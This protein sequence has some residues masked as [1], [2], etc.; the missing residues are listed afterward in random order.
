[1]T[2]IEWCDETINPIIGCAKISAGCANC[3]AE[4]MANCHA[5]NPKLAERYGPVITEGHW[6]GKTAFV[7][8]ELEKPFKWKKPK[9]IF[10]GSMGDLFHDRVDTARLDEILATIGSLPRHRFMFLTKR[11]D[12]MMIYFNNLTS[13]ERGVRFLPT[14]RQWPIP[15]LWLG[16]TI[17]NQK[18]ADERIPILLQIPAAKRF[19]S[20]EPMLGPIQL[21]HSTDGMPFIGYSEGGID[22]VICGAETGP[23]ARPMQAAWAESLRD[24][25]QAS[26]VPF[27]FKKFANGDT[28]LNGREWS[29]FPMPCKQKKRAPS[30]PMPSKQTTNFAPLPA[31][32]RKSIQ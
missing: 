8:S 17:E 11:A 7:P 12:A 30:S 9:R 20:V 13:S 31:E 10:V 27:F 16:V 32:T 3:Y 6:N 21:E 29:E 15:N 1:M 18:A 4:R 26:G 25:C 23:G 14:F 5:H 24:Q 19:V 28:K 22:W 2:K